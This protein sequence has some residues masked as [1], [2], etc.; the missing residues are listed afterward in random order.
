MPLRCWYSGEI[1]LK[2]LHL[3]ISIPS[4]TGH[5]HDAYLTLAPRA[6]CQASV[7]HLCRTNTER[8]S[9]TVCTPVQQLGPRHPDQG[10]ALRELLL[11]VIFYL[12]STHSHSPPRPV[13][14]EEPYTL[15]YVNCAPATWPAAGISHITLIRKAD[16]LKAPL[17][18]FPGKCLFREYPPAR[19]RSS[20]WPKTSMGTTTQ[21]ITPHTF[22]S[23]ISVLY[24]EFQSFPM[25][26]STLSDLSTNIFTKQKWIWQ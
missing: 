15:Q 23:L 5:H 22:V 25:Q 18:I 6:A 12:A 2:N 1:N 16:G 9:R 17:H 19:K 26:I 13:A 8:Y 4:L 11:N 21:T 20:C 10:P 24:W 3:I 14:S 7:G